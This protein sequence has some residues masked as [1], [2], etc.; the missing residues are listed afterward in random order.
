MQIAVLI[1]ARD[2]AP[3]IKDAIASVLAQTHRDWSLIVVDDG[4]TD[5]T[6]PAVARFKDPRILLL[7]Q[8][9]QGV[10]AARNAASAG[11]G[12][13][14]AMLF[15]DGDDWLAPDALAR[16][17]AGLVAYPAAV[18]THAPF[19][20]VTE[21]ATPLSPGRPEKRM[22]RTSAN[23][24]SQLIRGNIFANGGHVLIRSTAWTA[25]GPFR[26]DLAFGED[27]EF[28]TRL[29]LQGDF[30]PIDGP[31]VLY[32][33]RRQGGAMHRAATDPAAY[34]PAL[35]AIRANR[36]IAIRLGPGLVDRQLRAAEVEVRWVVGR[37]L[38]RRGD[39][40]DALRNLR[41]GFWA[42]PGPQRAALLMLAACGALRPRP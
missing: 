15:L 7:R 4:S 37:E 19:A 23:L 20:F 2:V 33:R 16:M 26:R 42:S 10:S 8:I 35:A 39:R 6:G 30:V 25:A 36:K 32:V 24:L 27:W 11:V 5:G 12:A 9:G 22:V 41:R 28:W 18:A 14:E 34:R 17:A 31:P 21:A 40:R 38:L 13:A 1:A 29:A 3:F